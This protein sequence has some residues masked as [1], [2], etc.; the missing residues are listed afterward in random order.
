MS[1]T[2]ARVTLVELSVPAWSTSRLVLAS[3]AVVAPVPPLSILNVAESV[4]AVS[5]LPVTFPRRFPVTSPVRSEVTMLNET[6]SEVPTAWPM[7][8]TL[9]AIVIPV[10]TFTPP[11]ISL[12]AVGKE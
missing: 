1:V 3:A 2:V 7:D 4:V 6:S 9:S 12:V 8:I 5:A 10:P 11:R